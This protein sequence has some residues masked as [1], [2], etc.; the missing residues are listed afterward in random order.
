M[1]SDTQIYENRCHIFNYYFSHQI[2]VMA[3]CTLFNRSRTWFYKW[4]RRYNLYGEA[5]LRDFDRG[6]PA[7]PNRTPLDIEMKNT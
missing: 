2:S 5:G 1:T 4:K 6:S 7:M 3:L